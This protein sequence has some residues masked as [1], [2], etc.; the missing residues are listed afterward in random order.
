MGPQPWDPNQAG[1]NKGTS[2]AALLLTDQPSS[3]T[4]IWQDPAAPPTRERLT[5]RVSG[6]GIFNCIV[7]WY[8]LDMGDPNGPL[9][10]APDFK[11]PRHMYYRAC[12]QRLFFVGFEQRTSPGDLVSVELLKTATAYVVAANADVDA[13]RAGSLV[14]WPMANVL[15]Y[16]FPMI[17]E[18]PRNVRFERA[19]LRAI[20]A[21]KAEHGRGPHV[22]D[23]G[24]GTG[25][26]AMMAA[27]GGARKVTSVEMVPAVCAV[28]SQIVQR[29]GYGD[30]VEVRTPLLPP[31]AAA[32]WQL[33]PLLTTPCRHV[34]GD[35]RALRRSLP[36]HNGR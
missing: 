28:A 8:D 5:A 7:T 30:I 22:L 1:P 17:A 15:S 2:A 21:Y 13:T 4:L 26:L 20:E 29:N 3:R 33:P 19:L 23:I 34:A 12:R 18:T 11:H 16:H 10:F 9:S 24:S 32:T 27:R 14:R 6:S 36:L 31:R 25:L 35:Q